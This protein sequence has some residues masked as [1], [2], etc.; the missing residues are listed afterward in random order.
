MSTPAGGDKASLHKPL[1]KLLAIIQYLMCVPFKCEMHI[2]SLP[3]FFL[4]GFNCTSPFPCLGFHSPASHIT[5]LP[6]FFHFTHQ[7]D[8]FLLHGI[9]NNF[10]PFPG[11]EPAIFRPQHWSA[12]SSQNLIWRVSVQVSFAVVTNC[13]FL[14]PTGCY[15]CQ[16]NLTIFLCY[17]LEEESYLGKALTVR[18][19]FFFMQV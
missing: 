8:H 14:Q 10:E 9:S 17:L 11:F 1:H 3:T 16:Y 5:F 6:C 7:I 13:S 18:G 4:P 12:F 2:K 15:H 19:G